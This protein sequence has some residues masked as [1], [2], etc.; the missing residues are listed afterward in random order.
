MAINQKIFEASQK[1]DAASGLEVCGIELPGAGA[2]APAP[3][4]EHVGSLHDSAAT[5]KRIAR[6]WLKPLSTGKE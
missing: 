2:V 6:I 1:S 4:R 3:S 5:L